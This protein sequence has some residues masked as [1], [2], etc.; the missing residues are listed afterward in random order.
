ML[1]KFLG[2]Q[3]LPL[4]TKFRIFFFDL[5]VVLLHLSIISISID[6]F[7]CNILCVLNA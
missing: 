6:Y 5:I 4:F 7:I 2:H 3:Q 1:D